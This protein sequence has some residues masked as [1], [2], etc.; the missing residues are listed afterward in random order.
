MGLSF[1]TS[2]VL[3]LP[4]QPQNA[5]FSNVVSAMELRS[6]SSFLT[7]IYLLSLAETISKKDCRDGRLTLIVV[8][9]PAFFVGKTP[10][11]ERALGQ[12]RT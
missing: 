2:P 12:Y 8:F 3:G 6:T 10:V 4:V 11:S 7:M 5:A 9:L 1:S